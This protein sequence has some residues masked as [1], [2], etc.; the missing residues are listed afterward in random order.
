M[1][2]VR[3]MVGVLSAALGATWLALAGA[4]PARAVDVDD[5]LDACRAAIAPG[6][7]WEDTEAEVR[8][9]GED[10]VAVTIGDRHHC[11]YNPASGKAHLIGRP[12]TT[13]P[14]AP[15]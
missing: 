3:G 13:G 15:R 5:A 12:S 2:P 9:E 10:R 4:P 6:R 14:G 8:K 1:V 11:V 7:N